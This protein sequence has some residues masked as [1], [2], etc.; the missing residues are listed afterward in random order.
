MSSSSFNIPI[1]LIKQEFKNN[2]EL[3]KRMKMEKSKRIL[4]IIKKENVKK[5]Y[6]K[7]NNSKEFIKVVN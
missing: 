4:V 1:E 3:L 2:Y 6:I 5:I 7:K